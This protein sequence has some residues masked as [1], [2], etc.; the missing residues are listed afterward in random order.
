MKRNNLI[1]FIII[2]LLLQSNLFSKNDVT[3]IGPLMAADG[4][5]R[6]SIGLLDHLSKYLDINYIKSG[7]FDLSEVPKKVIDILEKKDQSHA[8]IVLF[9]NS[10]WTIWGDRTVDLP[11]AK[12]KLAYSMIEGTGIP[13]EWVNAFNEKFDAVIVPDEFLIDIYSKCG[14]IIP[15][16]VIP[17]GLYLESFLIKKPK[18]REEK[19]FVFGM[20]AGFVPGKN[21]E[22]LIDAFFEEFKN[23]SQVTLKIHGRGGSF[24]CK[25]EEKVN[26]LNCKNIELI[27][28][29][30]SNAEYLSFMSS[31]DCYVLTSKGEGFSITP[32][33]A[34]AL[35]IPCILTNN[36]AQK[37]ICDTGF[38]CT[39]DS[40][41]EEPAFYEPFNSICGSKFNCAVLD[42]KNALRTVYSDYE[43]YFYLAQKGKEWVTKYLYAEVI[44]QYLTIIKPSKLVLGKQNKIEA[45]SLIT[46]SKVLY[47]KYNRLYFSQDIKE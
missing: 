31:L 21:Q 41:I 1:F 22:V 33:E 20:S 28:N 8:D 26:L 39:V 30:F 3:I 47:E 12:I 44:S 43:K 10:P 11:D 25:I 42:V 7:P 35:G 4:I 19:E 6:I 46:N 2:L 16:F 29:K 9:L 34:L 37:T 14:V 38:I 36:T 17:I 18:K 40:L 45:N 32:R 13:K 23:N 5:C 27:N 24:F 15:I